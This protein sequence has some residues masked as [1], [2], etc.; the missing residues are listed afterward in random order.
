VRD[1]GLEVNSSHL[2]DKVQRS[3]KGVKG[4][5]GEERV[6]SV[7][8]LLCLR[9]RVGKASTP[10][11]QA[12][13]G[14][15]ETSII[16]S[17]KESGTRGLR[18]DE[19]YSRLIKELVGKERSVKGVSLEAVEELCRNVGATCTAGR[20]TLLERSEKLQYQ[21]LDSPFTPVLA[22]YVGD[23]SRVLS[24]T[25][26]NASRVQEPPAL[27]RVEGSRGGPFY[28]AH[29]YQTK[30]PPEAIVPFLEHFTEP[31][32]LVLDPFCGSGMTGVAAALCGRRAI[33]NDLSVTAAH[34][35]FNH[36][37]PCDGKTLVA[38]FE[39][40]YKTLQP[41]FADLY[42]IRHGRTRRGYVHYTIWSRRY[43]CTACRKPFLF[44]D[45]IDRKTGKV[46]KSIR[47]PKCSAS[48]KRHSLVQEDSQPA[49]VSYEVPE[50]GRTVRIERRLTQAEQ[51]QFQGYEREKV[52]EWYPRLPLGPDREMYIR[53]ALHLQG[54]QEVA[55]FY[56]P[57][58]LEAL[59]R[60]WKAIQEVE[61]QRLRQAL[62]FAFTNT[63]WHGTR[64]RR[65][66]ARGGQRPLTGTLYIPQLSSEVNVLEVMRNK[67]QQLK[68]YYDAYQPASAVPPPVVTLGSATAL[69]SIPDASVDYVFTDPPFGS[70]IFYSDCNVIL[71]SWLGTVT[72]PAEEAV[73]NRSLP[74]KRGGKTLLDYES[75]MT[76]AL[77]EIHRVLKRGG[78][79]T[80]VFHNTDSDVWQAI[81]RSAAAARLELVDA[82]TLDRKQR[83]H[84]GYKG[85]DG[86]ENVAHYDVVMHLRKSERATQARKVADD[87]HLAPLVSR[88]C[89][90]REARAKGIQWVHSALMKT[91]VADGFDLGSIDYERVKALCGELLQADMA[92]ID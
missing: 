40:I 32:D 45:A 55:D 19:V 46:G 22:S 76:R 91:L 72:N 31:G 34:L 5:K 16:R 75:L 77:C 70:N 28:N 24:G 71:E 54:I 30:V 80:M 48:I 92:S 41:C 36:T 4:T 33:L 66:N 68:A 17:L 35:S 15:A 65:F 20:W 81:Q 6:T 37:Q 50:R 42:S 89:S 60:L 11:E 12:P 1:A 58:N 52:K 51:V 63:A 78:W 64:M 49:W 23:T 44:W 29:S 53:C 67:V 26:E 38:E 79:A 27:S 10:A 9:A 83:S 87:K 14:E 59:G 88:L 2:L 82:T 86:S 25:R 13:S 56:T 21:K 3:I 74:A 62:T 7:D 85:R 43:R 73:V 18:T 47:C 90:S 84:K 39:R 57:R 8:V 61:D 69:R